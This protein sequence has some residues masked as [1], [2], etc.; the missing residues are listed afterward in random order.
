MHRS[1]SHVRMLAAVTL[2]GVLCL[3]TVA[4][5]WHH[6]LDPTCGAEGRHGSQPCATCSALH[7]VPVLAHAQS[8]EP[9]VVRTVSEV[10]APARGRA[11]TPY[12]ITGAARAPPQT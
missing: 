1:G 9:P 7:S 12:R 10:L 11:S 4:H 3:G 5:L 2:L 6:L 8:P